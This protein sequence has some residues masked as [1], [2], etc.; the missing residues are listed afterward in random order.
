MK[1]KIFY[2]KGLT[3]LLEIQEKLPGVIT[4]GS[5]WFFF[6]LFKNILSSKLIFFLESESCT[7]FAHIKVI[8]LI[9]Y[10]FGKK[11]SWT[12]WLACLIFSSFPPQFRI[13]LR[14]EQGGATTVSLKWFV[15]IMLFDVLTLVNI[16]KISLSL[17]SFS[18]KFSILYSGSWKI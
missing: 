10:W 17:S 11:I 14:G 3:W 2:T 16:R 12:L 1:H 13:F 15:L 18:S 5:D 7:D 9:I 8:I 4:L 6:L